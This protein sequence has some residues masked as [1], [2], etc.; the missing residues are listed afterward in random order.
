MG[1]SVCSSGLAVLL[2]AAAACGGGEPSG[3]APSPVNPT[4]TP[5]T[6][7]SPS[8]DAQLD[9][10]RPTLTVRNGTS[11]AA[12][13]R[14]YEFQ[15]SDTREFA[16]GTASRITGF[17][18]TVSR[19]DVA[20]GPDG[21]TSFTPDRDLQPTTRFYWRARVRQGEA[22]SEWSTVGMFRTKLVGFFRDGEVF[23]PLI[24]GETVGER[25]GSTEFVPDRGLRLVNGNS[26]VRY[27]LPRPIASG[28]FSM[29]VEGLRPNGPGNKTKVFG[30]Q[31][32]T[33]DFITNRYRIDAQYRGSDGYP[34]NAIQWRAMFGSDDDK[35]EPDTAKRFASVFRLDPSRTYF[36]RGTWNNGFHLTVL[37]G[38]L[39]GTVLYDYGLTGSVRYAPR[40]HVA[41]LGA[42][43]GHDTIESA[44]IPGAIYR[45]VW[46]G[47]RPRPESLGS[48]L[49]ETPE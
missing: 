30:M 16:A 1:R 41:Y 23:D 40:A 32:G 21:R 12:G 10:L 49:W 44:S 28:E 3:P 7:E 36:W 25:V 15:V 9:T 42:P 6:V 46:I 24:H 22:V 29:E 47:N 31:D 4:L 2:V 34:P 19:A 48:A 39:S 26:Y 27:R 38:G 18:A 43:R 17:D 5:P 33:G 20:E 45:N 8:R 11:T 37:D 13:A 35:L 14:T